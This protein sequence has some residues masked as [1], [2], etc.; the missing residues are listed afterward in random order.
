MQCRATLLS[1]LRTPCPCPDTSQS[2]RDG[3][4][5]SVVLGQKSNRSRLVTRR[6]KYFPCFF[7]NG[8]SPY[9][10]PACLCLLWY[11]L[12][13]SYHSCLWYVG[14][15]FTT[16]WNCLKFIRA[17]FWSAWGSEGE[18]ADVM[19]FKDSGSADWPSIWPRCCELKSNEI[20]KAPKIRSSLWVMPELWSLSLWLWMSYFSLSF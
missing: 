15:L 14:S 1:L 10:S 19:W 8:M 12:S 16:W 4:T 13:S 6:S 2:C 7:F 11:V 5:S 18:K 17:Q 9:C 20:C 3:I